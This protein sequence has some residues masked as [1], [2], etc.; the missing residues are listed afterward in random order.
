MVFRLPMT[1]LISFLSFNYCWLATPRYRLLGA[2]LLNPRFRKLAVNLRTP[3]THMYS[4]LPWK[5]SWT[6]LCHHLTNFFLFPLLLLCYYS[7]QVT[8]SARVKPYL[9]NLRRSSQL[10][11]FLPRKC[12]RKFVLRSKLQFHLCS[13]YCCCLHYYSTFN[14]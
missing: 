3:V 13:F 4:D 1:Y 6:S 8:A 5:P 14:D 7:A 11:D 12:V 2:F 10:A 9:Q